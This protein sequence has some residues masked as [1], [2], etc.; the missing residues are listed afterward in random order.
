MTERDVSDEIPNDHAEMKRTFPK[1]RFDTKFDALFVPQA[2]ALHGIPIEPPLRGRVGRLWE[3]DESFGNG[4]YWFYAIDDIM[5]VA[6]YDFIF[7]TPL[8]FSCETPDFFC[9]GSYGKNMVPYF[10][11][12][13]D[14]ADRTL[15]GYAWAGQPYVQTT[16]ADE[17]YDVTS[18]VLL[19]KAMQLMSMRCHC[20][21]LVLSRAI[22][23]LD[24]NRDV[25]GLNQVFDE[26]RQARPSAVTA[27]AF[28]EAKITEAVSLLLDWNL[29][30][31]Q[32]PRNALRPSDR[33][34]LNRART[35]IENNVER[36]VSTDEIC[37][38]A[39][40]SPSKLTRLFKQAEGMTPQEYARSVRMDRAC[41][42]LEETD[43]PLSDVAKKLGF[44]RQGSFSE[45]FKERF[46]VTPREFRARRRAT[47]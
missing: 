17:Q 21:P 3:I 30:R 26:I 43:I 24:G 5:G 6:V 47:A 7:K 33:S 9:F 2:T 28:Y 13:T 42:M 22:A 4:T 25:L 10:G 35:H 45:A 14:P 44:A 34:A 23:S 29:L 40:A 38:I 20:D 32:E 37:R 31:A 39:C 15:L 36:H 41:R 18:I 16:K 19:P 1:A 11:K 27:H 46:G 8:E 12:N